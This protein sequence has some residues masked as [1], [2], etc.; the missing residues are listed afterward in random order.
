M[1]RVQ[2][3]AERTYLQDHL[4][5]TETVSRQHQHHVQQLQDELASCTLVRD[6]LVCPVCT[7]LVAVGRRFTRLRIRVWHMQKELCVCGAGAPKKKTGTRE[8]AHAS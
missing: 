2:V 6:I 3:Q 7:M 8:V 4:V 1:S 5:R